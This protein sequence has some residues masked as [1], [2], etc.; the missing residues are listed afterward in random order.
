MRYFKQKLRILYVSKKSFF[1]QNFAFCSN[2]VGNKNNPKT[3]NLGPSWNLPAF[4]LGWNNAD[5][6]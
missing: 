5:C 3:L 6:A 2:Q 1:I 4:V